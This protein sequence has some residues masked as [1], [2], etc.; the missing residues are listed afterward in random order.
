MSEAVGLLVDLLL[1]SRIELERSAGSAVAG[2][3]ASAIG[4]A[5]G[6]GFDDTGDGPELDSRDG[7]VARRGRHRCCAPDAARA[8]ERMAA[9]T[10]EVVLFDLDDTLFAHS[11]RGLAR[12]ARPPHARIGAA[13]RTTRA[14]FAR[15]TA[16]EEHHYHRYLSGELDYSSS[17]ARERAASSSRSAI[18]LGDDAVADE[19]FGRYFV[20]YYRRGWGLYDD[21]LPVLDALAASASASSPTAS[22]SFQLAKLDAMGI[23]ERFEHVIASG[24]VGAVKPDARIFRAAVQAFG[25]DARQAAYVGDRLQTD[26]IGAAEAGLLGVW[27]DR[28]RVASADELAVAAS[29]GVPRIRSLGEVAAILAERA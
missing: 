23:T 1:R 17:A 13:R 10:I 29:A 15:W 16:L 21:T 3:V 4:R 28:N 25:V 6:F 14:E 2:N 9:V 24:E 7:R 8:G 20:E 11:A 27:L 18:D 12:S 22:S 5:Q 26:A 19:W